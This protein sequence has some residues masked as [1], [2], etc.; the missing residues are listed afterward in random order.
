MV[1]G[2]RSQVGAA[3]W[4]RD[5]LSSSSLAAALAHVTS[6]RVTEVQRDS[7]MLAWTPVPGASSY[8]LSWT[9]P[10]GEAGGQPRGGGQCPRGGF[11][12]SP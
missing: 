9:P 11:A 7:V 3:P 12:S 4:G 1:G 5:T 6:L 8:V 2:A 10:T